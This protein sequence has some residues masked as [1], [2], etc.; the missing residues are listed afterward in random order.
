MC[1]FSE[2][3]GWSGRK[4]KRERGTS[5]NAKPIMEMTN[6]KPFTKREV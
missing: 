3:D 1:V 2:T 5:S 4:K 6:D